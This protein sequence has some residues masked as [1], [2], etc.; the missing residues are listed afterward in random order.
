MFEN[1][2]TGQV[3][4]HSLNGLSSYEMKTGPISRSRPITESVKCD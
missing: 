3:V 1:C 4:L 2:K